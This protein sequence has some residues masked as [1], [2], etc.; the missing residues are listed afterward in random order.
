MATVAVT[1]TDKPAQSFLATWAGMTTSD[2]GAEIDYV[3]H[4]DRTVQVFGA[5]GGATVTLQGSLDRSNWATLNDAQGNPI[6]ITQAKIEAITELVLW[7]RPH[8]SGGT[9]TNVTVSL[10]MRKT[11]S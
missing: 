9:G 5:F 2:V 4:A 3:G 11:M 8:V 7:I 10:L 6:E 1:V